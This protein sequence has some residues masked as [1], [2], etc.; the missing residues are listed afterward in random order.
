VTRRTRE[1]GV[2][3]ALGAE[4]GDLIRMVLAES[5]RLVVLGS[6]TGVLVAAAAS[7]LLTA[8]LFGIPTLD[9]VTFGGTI[10]LFAAIG[11]TASY[12][13]VCR[14]LRINPVEA[15]RYE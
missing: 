6:A 14:A 13:P 5:M 12:V 11:L 1:I 2:R 3:I 8:L 10:V 7:R 9:P 15:L 4:R